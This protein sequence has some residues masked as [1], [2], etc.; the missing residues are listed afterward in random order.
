MSVHN[1]FV[2]NNA[3]VNFWRRKIFMYAY[4]GIK[5][6]LPCTLSVKRRQI[7]ERLISIPVLLISLYYAGINKD[8][9]LRQT[10]EEDK[11]NFSVSENTSIN[12]HE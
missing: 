6:N 2:V 7:F 4:C 3:L 12:L 8:D 1:S 5:G 11:Y 9:K 10:I